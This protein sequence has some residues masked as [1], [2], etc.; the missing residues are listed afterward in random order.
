MV[1]PFKK[2]Y[3]IIQRL[4]YVPFYQ[5]ELSINW[6]VFAQSAN[7]VMGS[8]VYN[9]EPKALAEVPS[10]SAKKDVSFA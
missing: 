9:D 1:C 5:M 8:D 7:G 6:L 2:I 4:V 10:E 3:N